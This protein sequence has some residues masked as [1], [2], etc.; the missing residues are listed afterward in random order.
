V[1]RRLKEVLG[2]EEKVQNA[3]I[4]TGFL[5]KLEKKSGS[6]AAARIKVVKDSF[7]DL[8]GVSYQEYC[9]IVESL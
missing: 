2:S 3:L 1:L 4:L 6:V 8:V 5:S 7:R 9:R